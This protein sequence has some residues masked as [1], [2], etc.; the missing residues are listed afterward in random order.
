M[1]LRR[2]IRGVMLLLAIAAAEFSA[3]VFG[4]STLLQPGPAQ[5]AQTVPYKINFQGR[6]SDNSG[7]VLSDGLYNVKFRLWTLSS[8]GTNQWEADR[9]FG[10][11]DHRITV[12]NGLFNIQFGDATQGDPA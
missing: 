6:L 8:G 2:R 4:V 5:A 12:Q 11:S 7:N 1:E 3:A 9:V 10:A